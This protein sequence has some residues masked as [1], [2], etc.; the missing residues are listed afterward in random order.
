MAFKEGLAYLKRGC[1][2]ERVV[3]VFKEWLWCLKRG[4]DVFKE[5][6]CGI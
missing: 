5:R 4:C 6:L 2:V 3:V 1:G